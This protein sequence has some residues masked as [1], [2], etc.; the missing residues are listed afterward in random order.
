MK[1]DSEVLATLYRVRAKIEKG[2]CKNNH[3]LSKNG[4]SVDSNSM[5]AAKWCLVGAI[6]AETTGDRSIIEEDLL[7]VLGEQSNT[8]TA[9]QTLVDFND[10]FWTTKSRVLRRID[11]HIKRLENAK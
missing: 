6:H 10:S 7:T 1:T 3:A 4:K 8:V 11:K 9:Y 5:L 2:W